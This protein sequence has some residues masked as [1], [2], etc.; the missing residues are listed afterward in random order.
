M[1]LI[2][3]LQRENTLLRLSQRPHTPQPTGTTTVAIPPFKMAQ[4]GLIPTPLRLSLT[5]GSARTFYVDKMGSQFLLRHLDG[6]GVLNIGQY[7][8]CSKLGGNLKLRRELKVPDEAE[9]FAIAYPLVGVGHLHTAHKLTLSMADSSFMFLL[10]GGI[11]TFDK[12]QNILSSHALLIGGQDITFDTCQKWSHKHTRQ[13]HIMRR[14]QPV[15]IE[16]MKKPPAGAL[17]F[18]W[19]SPSEEFEDL[20]A[21]GVLQPLLEAQSQW[22]YGAF[23]YLFHHDVLGTQ[24]NDK[25]CYFPVRED[26]KFAQILSVD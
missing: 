5:V 16:G 20:E 15:T 8:P 26:C 13:L 4:F 24:E 1:D 14:F 21:R 7:S 18:S 19:V 22:K 10:F 25:D 12:H 17:Y 9:T 23:V 11:I 3:R 6:L 2:Q